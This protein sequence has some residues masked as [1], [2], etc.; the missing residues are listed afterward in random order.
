M[1]TVESRRRALVL[2]AHGAR[3]PQWRAPFEQLLRRTQAQ[4]PAVQVRLAFLEFMAP[5]LST[6]VRDLAQLDCDRL[7]LV[8]IFLGQGGHVRRDLPALIAQM[9]RDY[10]RMAINMVPAVGEDSAVL[11]AMSHYCIAAL[12]P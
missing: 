12:E 5:D 2:F 3:D 4:L 7:T 9:Q 10:P 1:E 11:D 8:P 6:A